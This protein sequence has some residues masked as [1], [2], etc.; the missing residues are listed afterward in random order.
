VWRTGGGSITGPRAGGGLVTGKHGREAARGSIVAAWGRVA[1]AGRAKPHGAGHMGP[2]SVGGTRGG[3]VGCAWLDQSIGRLG[4]GDGPIDPS[5]Y[6]I[7]GGAVYIYM[8]R[9]WRI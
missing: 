2:S 4:P 5:P 8:Y 6:V 9:R 1:R 7:N 3:C